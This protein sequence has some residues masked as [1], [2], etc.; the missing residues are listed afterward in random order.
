MRSDTL[1]IVTPI[2]NPIRW[3]SRIRLAWDAILHWVS[4][5]N[6]EVYVPE[7]AYG[8]HDHELTRLG[9]HPR[10]HHIPLRARSAPWS[11]EN[12][13]NI[14]ISRLPAEARF[15]GVFDADIH[16]CRPL[17][18]RDTVAALQIHPVVQPWSVCHDLGPNDE[19]LVLHHALCKLF[20]WGKPVAPGGP[21]FWRADGGPYEYAHSG[22]AW[23][24]T[25]EALDG[26]G[27][28]FELGGMGS[29]D[30][31][32]A[33]GLVGRA[34]CS[35]PGFTSVAYKEAVFRWQARALQAVKKNVGYVEC[36][37]EH[38]FHGPKPKR[39]Y[40][41]RWDMFVK[42]QFD[43]HVDLKRNSWGVFEWAGNKPELER[44]WHAY[45]VSRGEDGNSLD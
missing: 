10:I 9:D 22:F 24:W 12:L 1:H 42:H 11:K 29:G 21:K 27:G 16:F 40:I 18:S 2:A 14:G 26:V 38:K 20:R 13:I 35:M 41:G 32:M 31:H 25:R 4:E 23:A 3:K 44:D 5:P 6:V 8:A 45:L 33:L 36:R 34:E 39:N 28:L 7:V 19:H 43:P 15:I 30:Y 37:I 17:W